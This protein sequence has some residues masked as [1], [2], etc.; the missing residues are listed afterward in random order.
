MNKFPC[1]KQKRIRIIYYLFNLIS[2]LLFASPLTI[3][4][5]CGG[6][7]RCCFCSRPSVMPEWT[8]THREERDTLNQ[9]EIMTKVRYNK[10]C[11][12]FEI[13][14]PIQVTANDRLENLNN[15][16]TDSES[17]F[18]FFP[19]FNSMVFRSV[20]YLCFYFCIC[21]RGFSSISKSVL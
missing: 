7:C 10:S 8:Q 1:A 20:I 14:K 18:A 5:F 3:S 16:K 13:C 11:F 4:S 2:T 21:L 15:N 9:C 6:C 19:Q 17:G 12:P